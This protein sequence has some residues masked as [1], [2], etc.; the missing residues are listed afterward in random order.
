[1]YCWLYISFIRRRCHWHLFTCS[2][3]HMLFPV[4]CNLSHVL[5]WSHQ[6]F[7]DATD[8]TPET[9]FSIHVTECTCLILSQLFLNSVLFVEWT[10]DDTLQH[11]RKVV[12]CWVKPKI[13]FAHLTDTSGRWIK[14]IMPIL[15]LLLLELRSLFPLICR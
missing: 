12:V 8:R 11:S 2:F 15:L 14:K 7:S 10:S 1:M 6:S 9:Q 5:A 3:I 13:F 4:F